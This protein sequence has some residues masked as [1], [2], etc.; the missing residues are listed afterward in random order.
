MTV[1]YT[2]VPSGEVM[3]M[4][5]V[6]RVPTASFFILAY[7]ISWIFW[8][9]LIFVDGDPGIFFNVLWIL[10]GLGPFAAAI[11]I[12]KAIGVFRGFKRLLFMWRVGLEWYL[13]ALALPVFI[14]AVSYVVFLI[15]GGTPGI[16]PET[17]PLYFYPLLLL[18]VMILGG[19]LEEPGWRGFALP[20][21]LKRHNP[22]VASMLIGIVWA[23]W[24][25]PLFFAPLSSQFN[26]PFG[27]YFINTLALS[28][29][30]TWL[31]L[32]SSGSTVTAIVLHGGINAAFTWYPGLS[33]VP[34]ALGTM[35]YYAPITIGSWLIAGL[36]LITH[37]RRFFTRGDTPGLV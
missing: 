10:G 9:P 16:S 8:I 15:A 4:K 33:N 2:L 37:R 28:V 7:L 31:F 34:T 3:D 19:G 24:H 20:M 25:L 29:M 35:H 1:R 30:F 17:P 27:W 6:A 22:F 32:K 11:L 14:G 18:F 21:L 12:S 26:L 13:V 23:F 36:L 5:T